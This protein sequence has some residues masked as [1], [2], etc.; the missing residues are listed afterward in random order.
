[1]DPATAKMALQIA[2]TLAR[3]RTF[4]YVVIASVLLTMLTGA[5]IVLGPGILV[6][7]IAASMRGK[8]GQQD[9]SS[10]DDCPA[11][12]GA[13]A[14]PAQG[15]TAEQ[16]GNARIIWTV[17]RQMAD[18]ERGAVVGIATA[19]QESALRNLPYGNLDSIGLFQQRDSWG[20][21]ATR[22]NPVDS[23][24]L[25]F[26]ALNKVNGWQKMA[27]DVAAQSVQRS[28][29]PTAYAN[30]VQASVNLVTFLETKYAPSSTL[31]TATGSG[32]CDGQT[33]TSTSLGK[34]GLPVDHYVLTA[35]FGQCGSHWANCHTGL[36][37]AAATGTPI[38]AVM[39]GKVVW[40]G[41]GG[42]Y[43][44]LTKIQHPDNVQTWYAHQSA[45]EVKAGDTVTAGQTIGR[46]GATGNTTGPHVHL[47]VRT[48]GTPVDPNKWLTAHGVKP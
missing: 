27:V 11:Q 31:E 20:S 36:D 24:K 41:W 38:H 37:F 10:A 8:G 2:A 17:A 23:S 14:A 32:L 21:T 30:Q 13:I 28:A 12:I 44:N 45:I 34:I 22:L 26:R 48:N 9:S 15:F 19:L 25:F 39:A 5:T 43:G 35:G 29:F 33:A 3:S 6:T 46:V 40:T 4:R 7:E 42:A 16:V 1:M 47:E 18:G